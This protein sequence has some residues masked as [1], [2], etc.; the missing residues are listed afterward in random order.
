MYRPGTYGSNVR[1]TEDIK[2]HATVLIAYDG[3][4][5]I[6]WDHSV[7]LD[8]M[9]APSLEQIADFCLVDNRVYFLYKKESE[10]LI[11][12]VFLPDHQAT[13]TKEKIRTLESADQIR[14]ERNIEGGLRHWYGNAFYVWG[15]QTL[16]NETK[17]D[18]V[19]EVFYINKVNAG[20]SG[21]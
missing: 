11:K 2:T 4:G 5:K 6:M 14:D 9:A 10:I 21:E 17:E 18:R 16:K 19:R 20:S 15:Y 12:S 3:A 8:D 13:E 7:K 1:N